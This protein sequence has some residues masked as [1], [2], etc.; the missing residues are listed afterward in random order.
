[1]RNAAYC[2]PARIFADR[3]VDDVV[4]RDALRTTHHYPDLQVILQIVPHACG[5][6]HDIDAM[7]SQEVSRSHARELQQL[8]R[9]ERASR[10]PVFPF[11][12]APFAG[13]LLA[14]FDRHRAA[15]VEHNALRQR[16]CLDVQVRSSLGG[17][18]IRH[19][20]ARPSSA[21]RRALEKSGAFLCRAVEVRIL[22]Y[23]G[24][25]RRRNECRGEGIGKVQIGNWLRAADAV[26]IVGAALLVLRFLEIRQDVVIA[27]AQVA[28]LAPAVVILVLAANVKQAVDRTRSAQHLAAR[29]KHRSPFQPRFG[30]GLVHP[31]DGL[32]LEQLA[33]SERHMDPGIG[34]FRAGLKQQYRILSV[35]AQ[36]IG[37]HA[38]GR[39]RTN[40]NVVEF[41]N[42]T[43]HV[44][45]SPNPA[46]PRMAQ[47]VSCP[48]DF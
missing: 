34:V 22:G 4:Q 37:E 42:F 23:A 17:A 1:M 33:I 47:A 43:L 27:P 36:T 12:P 18:K 21:Q 19:C 24:L 5:I 3:A 6:E 9:I 26:E 46:A 32:F 41:R 15:P 48:T 40:D 45:I 20:R 39:T 29:L 2:R 11:A 14:V 30:L 7:L 16:R 10:K 31:V 28:A 25:C 8:R 38:S 35:R 13:F 44:V